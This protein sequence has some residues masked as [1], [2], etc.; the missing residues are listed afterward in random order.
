CKYIANAWIDPPK[1]KALLGWG[2]Q[3]EVVI[4]IKLR[5]LNPKAQNLYEAIALLYKLETEETLKKGREDSRIPRVVS[6]LQALLKPLE[7]EE[8][9]LYLLDGYDEIAD[10]IDE[11]RHLTDTLRSKPNWIMTT[12]PHQ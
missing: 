6:D 1:R 3:F 7:D 5:E 2:E 9:I 12:R 11:Y 8:K 4:W 10:R